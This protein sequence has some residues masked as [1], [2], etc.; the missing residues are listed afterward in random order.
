MYEF[1]M[2][3]ILDYFEKREH[4][5]HILDNQI[6]E[7]F[8]YV[9][10]IGGFNPYPKPIYKSVDEREKSEEII[11]MFKTK[12]IE[13]YNPGNDIIHPEGFSM[14]IK[15]SGIDHP[16]SGYGVYVKG[17]VLPGT[18]LAFYPGTVYHPNDIKREIIEGNEYM[19]CRFDNIII[20]G[21]DWDK[22]Q[23]KYKLDLLKSKYTG[24]KI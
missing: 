14:V 2:I 10:S 23:E 6:L 8:K 12:D 24:G 18:V 22:R 16:E 3:S 11:R 4:N 21:S 5:I 19:Y 13:V 9:H 1:K 17:T 7:M 20:D 15:K